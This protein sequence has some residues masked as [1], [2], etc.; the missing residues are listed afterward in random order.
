MPAP[1]MPSYTE[2]DLQ[3][4]ISLVKGKEL[5]LYSACKH[6]NIPQGTLFRRLNGAQLKATSAIEQQHLTPA[7]EAS[8]ASWILEQASRGDAPS[9]EEVFGYATAILETTGHIRE[10]IT[11]TKH[12]IKGFNQRND[13]KHKIGRH[14]E[15][16]R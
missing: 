5:S 10:E 2:E 13:I 6:Y 8:L 12:W 1:M 16:N 11:L 3:K 15:K 14:Q 7:Q 9:R 4:A